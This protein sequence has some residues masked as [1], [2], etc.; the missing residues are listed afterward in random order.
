MGTVSNALYLIVW[1]GSIGLVTLW[2]WRRLHQN[3]PADV[4]RSTRLN[5]IGLCLFGSGITAAPAAV[6]FGGQTTTLVVTAAMLAGG[7]LVYI[8]VPLTVAGERSHTERVRQAFGGTPRQ[9]MLPVAAVFTLWLLLT[10]VVII[11]TGV[12]RFS[13]DPPA[14]S[15]PP[16]PGFTRPLVAIVAAGCI[17]GAMHGAGS[18]TASVARTPGSSAATGRQPRS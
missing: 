4:V 17:G 6:L 13:L 7:G 10:V 8:V 14:P 3:A 18:T 16:D 5:T 9:R 1:T 15:E 2:W 11:G 12:I